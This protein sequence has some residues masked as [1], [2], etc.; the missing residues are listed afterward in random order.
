MK[1]TC[2][3]RSEINR[4]YTSGH[5]AGLPIRGNQVDFEALWGLSLEAVDVPNTGRGGR[6]EVFLM[7]IRTGQTTV[8]MVVKRQ[9]NHM[10][11]SIISVPTFR[12]EYR[13]IRRCHRLS[14]PT[15]DVVYY[16]E[17]RDDK[18]RR[19]ILVTEFLQGYVS[20]D[21]LL[22]QYAMQGPV[23]KMERTA[24][25]QAVARVIRK[26][27]RCRLSHGHLQPKHILLKRINGTIDVRLI[28]LE[29]MHPRLAI[30][31]HR[32]RDLATLNRHLSQCPNPD[33]LRFVLAYTG[34]SRLDRKTKRLCHR[35][36]ARSKQKAAVKRTPA[37]PTHT[38]SP[39]R[40][41]P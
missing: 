26:V 2:K 5:W 20:L 21:S 8:T 7:P 6:S 23:E 33:K 3:N 39:P 38:Q 40:S 24:V 4:N 22:R 32:I 28:D 13:N 29:C 37:K 1:A 9:V 12:R 15:V 25:T 41:G 30:G 31:H 36:L 10:T 27:H 14:I 11:H 34:V 18:G 19:A 35:I 17:R 16:G